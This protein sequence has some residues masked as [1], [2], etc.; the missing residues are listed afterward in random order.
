MSTH[1][2][3]TIEITGWDEKPYA[4]SDGEQTLAHAVVTHKYTGDIE[5]EGRLD[6]LL[7]YT[8]EDSARYVG[9][10]RVVGSV[11][12]RQG[13]F[14]LRHTGVFAD[15]AARTEWQVVPGSGLAELSGLSGNGGYTASEGKTIPGATL[16]YQ[17][18]A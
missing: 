4:E 12:G 7:A 18:G 8:G 14:L 16:S 11:H 6:L 17:L 9:H 15:G 2:S 13:S 1:A 3:T 5:G 10:E